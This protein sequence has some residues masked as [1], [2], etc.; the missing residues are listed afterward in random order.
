MEDGF[1]DVQDIIPLPMQAH[2]NQMFQ[3]AGLKN[4]NIGEFACVGGKDQTKNL[5]K[6]A[7]V[8]EIASKNAELIPKFKKQLA[9]ILKAMEKQGEFQADVAKQ[10]LATQFNIQK[11][12]AGTLMEIMG[13]GGKNA[14]LQ[15]KVALYAARISE[16]DQA[17][18]TLCA[19]QF[20][21]AQKLIQTTLKNAQ[22]REKA[23]LKRKQHVSNKS[24]EKAVKREEW[25]EGAANAEYDV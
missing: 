20:G 3:K 7:Q 21:N 9:K 15:R 18:Q 13:F 23:K 24:R 17:N 4:F 25:R 12:H 19:T 5:A 8:A 10:S 22:D 1:V 2:I 14:Q 11:N 16:Q 6:I